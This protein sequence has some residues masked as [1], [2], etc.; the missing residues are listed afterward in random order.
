MD[1]SKTPRPQIAALA[2]FLLAVAFAAALIWTSERNTQ[3]HN[4]ERVAAQASDHAH[5]LQADIERALS[6]AYALAALVRQG[7][8]KID[9]FDAVA[10][11][12]LRFYPGVAALGLSPE[13]VIRQVFPLAGNEKTIGFDQLHDPVQGKEARI[14]RDTGKLT[15][16]GPMNLV[17]GG[18]GAVGR[19]PVFLDDR[20][21]KEFFWGFAYVVIRFPQVLVGARLAELPGQGFDYELS[22]IHPES[23]QLQVIAASGRALSAPVKQDLELAH[24]NW[25]LSVAPAGGWLDPVMLLF[26]ALLGLVFSLLL[27]YV[28]FLMMRLKAQQGKLEQK[29]VERTYALANANDELARREA[30]FKQLLDTSNVAIFLVDMHGRITLANQRMAEMF[31]CTQEGLIGREY[32]TLV[33]PTERDEGRKKMID[34]LASKTPTVDLDRQ[35]WRDDHS[36]FWGHLSGRRF[37]D[38]NGTERGLIGVIADI[39]ARKAAEEALRTRNNMLNAVVEHFPGGISVVDS[40]LRV[41]IYNDQFKKLLSFPDSLFEKPDLHFDDLIRFNAERGEYG[42]GDR[43]Q[44]TAALVERARHFEPHHLERERPDGSALEI[45]GMPLPEGGFVSIYIDITERKRTEDQVKQLA[46]YDPLTKLPNRRLLTDRLNQ[47]MAASKRSACYG[48]LMF[49]DLDNFKPLNDLH[50]HEV[51]DLLLIE[52]AERM[53]RCVRGIDTVARFG[54]DEF[55]VVLGD[56]D[57]DEIKSAAESRL[58]AEKIRGALAEPYLLTI[59][60]EEKSDETVEHAC[61]ASIGVVLFLGHDTRQED[62]LKR[63]DSAMYRAKEAGR[64]MVCFYPAA[65]E[66]AAQETTKP[67]M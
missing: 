48:A 40:D 9:N 67:E 1:R 6:A 52:V 3:R 12:M 64:N 35:Y 25:T 41:V 27:G 33:H 53:K 43:E 22:R 38:A 24:G 20:Y 14:A 36:K 18:L 28:A 56:L 16:A 23:G 8:G 21:D 45:R 31:G 54:G 62:I 47:T 61:G 32:V 42:P 58:V 49:V 29:V 55:V 50:G 11:E 60:R 10:A 51:G 57:P 39:S 4:R 30:L 15:L 66:A 17:Q 19:L 63:A 46:F 7:N 13:G 59:R 65:P 26:K 2:V 5:A 34:L 44:Q 37:H